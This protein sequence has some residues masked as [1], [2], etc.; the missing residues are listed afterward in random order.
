MEA[1]DPPATYG[2][3]HGEN[4]EN[5]GTALVGFGPLHR[6]SGRVHTTPHPHQVSGAF[7]RTQLRLRD[8]LRA[9][10][11]DGRDRIFTYRIRNMTISHTLMVA[12]LACL[13]QSG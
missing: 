4:A 5:V 11:C 8:S 9:P 1:C 13:R 2:R 10:G 7:Q 3:P 6:A 12:I